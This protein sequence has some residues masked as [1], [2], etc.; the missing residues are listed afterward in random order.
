MQARDEFDPFTAENLPA[1]HCAQLAAKD[2]P[3]TVEY[4][5]APHGLHVN[6]ELACDELE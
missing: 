1:A 6:D 2:S 3:A 5:P 4:V